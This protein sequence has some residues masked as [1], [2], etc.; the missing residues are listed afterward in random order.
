L[1]P[2]RVTSASKSGYAVEAGCFWQSID[3]SQT[4]EASVILNCKDSNGAAPELSVYTKLLS[5]ETAISGLL[6]RQDSNQAELNQSG[7]DYRHCRL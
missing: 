4:D 7:S 1:F 2:S 3:C 5:D 6:F